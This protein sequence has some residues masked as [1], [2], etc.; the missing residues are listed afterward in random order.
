M[1]SRFPLNADGSL[2]GR[3]VAGHEDQNYFYDT[4]ESRKNVLYYR[5][6][7][8]D[9][10]SEAGGTFNTYTPRHLLRFWADYN[11]PGELDPWTVGRGAN[12]QSRNYHGNFGG[13]DGIGKI[14]QGG[15]A[16][17]NARVAYQI[18]KHFS[19]SLNG[20]NLFD[21]KYYSSIG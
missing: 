4:A 13:A 19:V 8:A 21:K 3:L 7:P 17:W 2:R 1:A 12:I 11:L 16:I 10:E 14:E 6:D 5:N 18:N 20:N 9:G 15:Y